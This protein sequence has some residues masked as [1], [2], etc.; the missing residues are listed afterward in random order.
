MNYALVRSQPIYR[1]GKS[2]AADIR[3]E[4]RLEVAEMVAQGGV[5]P[6]LAVLLVGN[7]VDSSTY[8]RMKAKACEEVGI[9]SV[10]LNLPETIT[11][12]ELKQKGTK[13]CLG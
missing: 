9:H 10:T 5:Q 7:R 4:L 13:I 11:E 6:G 1:A 8:V 12:D 2:I 3:D